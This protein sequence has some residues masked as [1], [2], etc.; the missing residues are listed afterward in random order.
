MEKGDSIGGGK[1]QAEE[2]DGESHAGGNCIG[3]CSLWD[4]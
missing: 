4:R 2:S 1:E 3:Q